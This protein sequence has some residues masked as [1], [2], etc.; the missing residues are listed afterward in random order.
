MRKIYVVEGSTGEYSDHREWP[1]RAFVS[2][3]KAQDF[4]E[5][6]SAEYRK[7]VNKYGGLSDLRWDMVKGKI[8][9]PLDPRME[10]DYTG[11]NYSY[12][13]IDLDEEE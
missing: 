6:V 4:V 3:N 8:S 12:F 1:V 2:E 10:V 9:N 7:L 11:T 5:A 13:P